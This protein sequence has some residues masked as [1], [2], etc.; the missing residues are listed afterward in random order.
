MYTER[1]IKKQGKKIRTT[2][3][4]VQ[5]YYSVLPVID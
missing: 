3:H 2:T 4:V 5:P 1:E